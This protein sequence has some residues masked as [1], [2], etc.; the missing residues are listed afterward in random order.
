MCYNW[1]QHVICEFT[2]IFRQS[3]HKASE[4]FRYSSSVLWFLSTV[5]IW[6][7]LCV[8]CVCVFVVHS[9][10]TCEFKILRMFNTIIFKTFI[11]FEINVVVFFCLVRRVINNHEI[12]R[13]YFIMLTALVVKVGNKNLKPHLINIK[14][15]FLFLKHFFSN[16]WGKKDHCQLK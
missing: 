1:S 10:L 12:N 5:G 2:K 7:S 13:K 14:I 3:Y 8:F 6:D 4:N 15:Y 11:A 16:E 9:K